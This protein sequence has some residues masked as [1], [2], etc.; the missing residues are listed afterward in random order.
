MDVKDKKIYMLVLFCEIQQE[1]REIVP[2]NH[3]DFGS[4][5]KCSLLI[6]FRTTTEDMLIIWNMK[7]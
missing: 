5:W 7:P 3:T 2:L 4:K 1:A 6:V